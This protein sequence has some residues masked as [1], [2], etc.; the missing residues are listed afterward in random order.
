MSNQYCPRTGQLSLATCTVLQ[1]AQVLNLPW[2]AAGLCCHPGLYRARST[3]HPPLGKCKMQSKK[4]IE[5]LPISVPFNCFL[6]AE[7]TYGNSSPQQRVCQT[8]V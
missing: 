5:T 7:M 6:L 1:K 4:K 3:L 2:E 8:A